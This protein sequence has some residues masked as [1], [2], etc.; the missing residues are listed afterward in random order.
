MPPQL[1][2]A[3]IAVQRLDLISVQNEKQA[4]SFV[5]VEASRCQPF[6][7]MKLDFSDWLTCWIFDGC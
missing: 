6:D 7:V 1:C 2:M 4:K 5:E 3:S